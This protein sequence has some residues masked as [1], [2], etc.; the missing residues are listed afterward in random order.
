MQVARFHFIPL[1]LLSLS[2]A[3]LLAGSLYAQPFPFQQLTTEVGLSHNVSRKIIQ[4]KQ[5][6]IWIATQDGLNRYDGYTFRTYSHDPADP[7]SL[8]DNDI[9]ALKESRE[10][11]LLIGTA[12]GGLNL[13]HP[14]CDCFSAF[15]HD[16]AD[17]TSLSSN[18]VFDVFED[19]QGQI[20]VGTNRGLDKLVW[21]EDNGKREASF[22][23]Y[24]AKKGDSQ[25][26]IANGAN[27][28]AQ[29]Q[30]GRLWLASL[31]FGL[32][33]LDQDAEN[34]E[35]ARFQRFSP[36]TEPQ[37][38]QLASGTVNQLYLDSH[39]D[40][41]I[42]RCGGLSRIPAAELKKGNPRFVHYDLGSF[43]GY[44]PQWFCIRSIRED[45]AGGLWIADYYAYHRY[46]RTRDSF[47]TVDLRSL[48]I[49]EQSENILYDLLPDRNG[50]LWLSSLLGVFKP[51]GRNP[52]FHN[53][54]FPD[55]KNRA[56]WGIL[57]D[58]YGYLWVG[59]EADGLWVFDT[60]KKVHRHF[61]S[62]AERPEERLENDFVTQLFEDTEG[63]LWVG[64][65][66]GQAFVWE[67]DRMKNGSIVGLQ[68][69]I[70]PGLSDS[71][72][73]RCF[74]EG[75]RGRIW[76][77][78]RDDLLWVDG[79][80]L[81]IEKR[82]AKISSNRIR[83]GPN[84]GIW[85][86]SDKGLLYHEPGTDSLQGFTFTHPLGSAL[87]P[88]QIFDLAFQ[89]EDSLWLATIRGLVL[90]SR[91]HGTFERYTERDGLPG[92]QVH[93]LLRDAEH[94]LWLGTNKGLCQVNPYNL[95]FG[96]YDR[97]DGIGSLS[98][99]RRARHQDPQG[100]M[101]FGGTEGLLFFHP[102]S[103][104]PD[105]TPPPVRLTDFQIFY[106]PVPVR[107][108]DSSITAHDVV[109]EQPIGQLEEIRLP[110]RYRILSFSY[111]ALDYEIPEK[112]QYAYQMVGFD[113]DWVYAGDRR[114]ATY[115]N[116]SPG[117]YTFR[118]KASNHDGVW[119][120]EGTRLR[121]V[122]DPPWWRSWWAY[123]LYGTVV[124]SFFG[125]YL[126]YRI[127]K[128]SQEYE[129]QARLEQ[130]R[131]AEREAVRKR[132][133]RD[134][135]DEAGNKLTKLSLYTELT[136]RKLQDD[137]EAISFLQQIES[138]VQEL[139]SGMR[140]FIWV[141]DPEKDSLGDTV[142]RLKDFGEKLFRDSSTS[143]RHDFDLEKLQ[144]ISL[145]I[146]AKRHLLLIFK[147]AMNNALKYAEADQ[148]RLEVALS[149]TLFQVVFE[150]DGKGFELEKANTGN[151]LNNMQERAREM[152]GSLR[153]AS[154][155]GT[156]SRV[157]FEMQITH[158]GDGEEGE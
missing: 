64:G 9:Y 6:F 87:H 150:D 83:R 75:P 54:A 110:Y 52:H 127:R 15:L 59:T 34:P 33:L 145:G 7:R 139:S 111:V 5:G 153:F 116:L 82:F 56:C 38:Q 129:T 45:E 121:V 107:Y 60:E 84:G 41:W 66:R 119:N 63:R 97:Q 108:P 53:L 90:A 147:E 137:P 72:N 2:V 138:N 58:R 88:R 49:T 89:G 46:H 104:R 122:I 16:P 55:G 86:A 17:S 112:N 11:R 22:H 70:I 50:N 23:H 20:W 144:G 14:D 156:G 27:A 152:G 135:H 29:D 124:M 79:N 76:L 91:K 21:V 68:K 28:I 157:I 18:F 61:H 133:A 10:G 57:T 131:Q 140:D 30:Q 73:S 105:P 51:D 136:K 12:K 148:A 128:V 154:T 40:L 65:N 77:G 103:I 123:F 118:V 74:F 132:S 44:D 3:S 62:G 69:N 130:A 94:H 36:T 37:P 155:P 26:L 158:M 134:F 48:L 114:T 71:Q 149:P 43:P 141:L 100:N 24:K 85:I 106:K 143:F 78:L 125:I 4:D 39:G 109:L 151:G 95:K 120:E 117:T 32:S 113:Q 13:Y 92:N 126:Y 101:Y 80:S 96:V 8:S 1:F 67:L 25:S 98:L 146:K 42:G 19:G 115:T 35:A 93:S 142:N 102:D 81:Q 31:Q 47:E 99:Q